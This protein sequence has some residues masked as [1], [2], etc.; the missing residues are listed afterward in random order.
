[1]VLTV[2]IGNSNI[3]IGVFVESKLLFTSR[4]SSNIDTTVDELA[5]M[6]NEIFTIRNIDRREINGAI[7][8]SVVPA[9]TRL[10]VQA[11][12]LITGVDPLIVAPGIKTGL[13]IKIDNPA[14]LGSD[15]LVNCVAASAKY[16]KPII[17]IDM[18]TATTMSV[19]DEDNN[20]LGGVIMPGVKTALNALISRTAQL[21]QISI[22]SPASVIG[23]NTN[24]SMKSGIVF[25]NASMLDG[26]IQRFEEELGK[27]VFVVATGGLSENICMHSKRNILHNPNLLLE[28]LYILY[29]KNTRKS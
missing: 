22:D 11:I 7:L 13:N 20:M 24:D 19:V 12:K 8:S 28:G 15:M 21:P 26:M 18:G 2:D 4:I 27:E 16:P 9:L 3:V 23:T 17:I 14:Q 1:M 29:N 5:V 10:M 6:M 25:G